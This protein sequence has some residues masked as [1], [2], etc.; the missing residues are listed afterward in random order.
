MKIFKISLLLF[1]ITLLA[2]KTHTQQL[3]PEVIPSLTV[4]N[5]Y[6]NERDIAFHKNI[7]PDIF[8][9]ISIELSNQSL[10]VPSVRSVY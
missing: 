4:L 8:L 5:A 7:F 3:M 6:H 10:K 2:S 9:G 1:A